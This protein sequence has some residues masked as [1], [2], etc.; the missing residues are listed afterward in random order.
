MRFLSKWGAHL[1]GSALPRS[2]GDRFQLRSRTSSPWVWRFLSIVRWIGR[3]TSSLE[4]DGNEQV[5]VSPVQNCGEQRPDLELCLPYGIHAGFLSVLHQTLHLFRPL[6]VF[7]PLPTLRG[8]ERTVLGHCR[9]RRW[10]RIKYIICTLTSCNF[11]VTNV[12]VYPTVMI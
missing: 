11:H 4:D 12:C 5:I 9:R 3:S 1:G 6:F 7:L 10:G 8:L 2:A